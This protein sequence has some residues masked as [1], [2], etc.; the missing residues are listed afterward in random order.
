MKGVC[1]FLRGLRSSVR[2]AFAE[3]RTRVFRPCSSTSVAFTRFG[4]NLRL[5]WRCEWETL[6]PLI[7]FFP[8]IGQTFDIR[9][10][11]SWASGISRNL[12]WQ[13]GNIWVQ[14]TWP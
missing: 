3:I 12:V 9:S 8:V 11:G 14:R 1:Y 2:S 4:S 6:F 7:A 10:P 13:V 5:V